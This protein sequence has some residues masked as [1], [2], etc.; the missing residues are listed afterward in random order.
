MQREHEH[1]LVYLLLRKWGSIR[2]K[3][4]FIP[5]MKIAKV[6]TAGCHCHIKTPI[7]VLL[8][9]I[10]SII[11]ESYIKLGKGN[12]ES[13][14][15]DKKMNN[16]KRL[17]IDVGFHP[18]FNITRPNRLQQQLDSSL[19]F[20]RSLPELR[21]LFQAHMPGLRSIMPFEHFVQPVAHWCHVG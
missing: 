12:E 5:C 18:C 3:M 8:I 11:T 20:S 14:T 10:T 19:V 1:P 4:T 17:I 21:G 6:N 13:A 16:N 7:K 2:R 15:R 9:A